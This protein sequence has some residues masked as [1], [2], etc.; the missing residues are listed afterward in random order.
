MAQSDEEYATAVFKSCSGNGE[1]LNEEEFR[2][3]LEKASHTRC[4]DSML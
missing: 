2:Y 4:W 3:A 1:T